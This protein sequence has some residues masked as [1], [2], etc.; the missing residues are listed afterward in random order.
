MARYDAD[1]LDESELARAKIQLKSSLLMSRESTSARCEQLA[2]HFLIHGR[3][4]DLAEIIENVEKVDQDAIRRVVARLLSDPP[5][6]G[7]LILRPFEGAL[8]TSASGCGELLLPAAL[9]AL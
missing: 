5:T 6:F 9:S 2:N 3:A 4:P 1:E 8:L 7:R